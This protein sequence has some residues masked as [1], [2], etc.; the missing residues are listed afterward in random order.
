MTIY[1]VE[2]SAQQRESLV[3]EGRTLK[4]NTPGAAE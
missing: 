4:A 2:P 1:V 3:G